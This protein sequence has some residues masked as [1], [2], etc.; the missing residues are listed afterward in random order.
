MTAKAKTILSYLVLPVLGFPV[1]FV[2]ANAIDSL[3]GEMQLIVRLLFEPA[4]ELLTITLNDWVHSIPMM[5]AIFLGLFMPVHALLARLGRLT[6]GLFS[7]AVSAVMFMFSYAAGFSINGV[8]ANTLT[9]MLL[10]ALTVSFARSGRAASGM[11]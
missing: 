1:Y 8:M 2:I 7:S 10:A 3:F 4:P 5:F 6:A 11:S 9:V